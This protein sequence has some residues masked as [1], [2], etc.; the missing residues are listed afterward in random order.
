M[1]RLKFWNKV[2]STEGGKLLNILDKTQGLGNSPDHTEM[3]IIR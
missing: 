2:H 1:N 3:L